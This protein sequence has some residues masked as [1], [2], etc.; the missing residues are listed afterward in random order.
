MCC[1]YLTGFCFLKIKWKILVKSLWQ[2]HPSWPLAWLVTVIAIPWH[3]K[4][5]KNWEKTPRKLNTA[6]RQLSPACV[7]A[8]Q[9]PLH[10]KA[11]CTGIL[12]WHASEKGKYICSVCSVSILKLHAMHDVS[13]YLL[14]LRK[15]EMYSFRIDAQWIL[16]WYYLAKAYQNK[17]PQILHAC[18]PFCIY[19]NCWF[20]SN[21][22]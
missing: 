6:L 20:P 8:V 19:I 14:T 15:G 2:E 22:R 16:L 11:K 21:P 5:F 12:F 7:I 10:F 13:W 4:L 17:M 9:C 1:D 18:C 3:G